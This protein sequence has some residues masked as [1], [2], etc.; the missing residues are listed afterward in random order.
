M[1]KLMTKIVILGALGGC[2]SIDSATLTEG[3]ELVASWSKPEV[4]ACDL[5]LSDQVQSLPSDIALSVQRSN[6]GR[7]DGLNS[8]RPWV[9]R[10]DLQT[11]EFG[12]QLISKQQDGQ[13]MIT[14][15]N[16]HPTK[17]AIL[18]NHTWE[19][20]SHAL[21]EESRGTI[22]MSKAHYRSDVLD[23]E[24]DTNNV[25]NLTNDSPSYYNAGAILFGN[26]ILFTAI[27]EGLGRTW[28]MNLD[29]SHKQPFTLTQGYTY[30]N[31]VSPDG[32]K[33]A[34]HAN[35][36]VFIGDMATKVET[37][38]QTPCNF[39]FG[40]KWSKDSQNI[41]FKCGAT[42]ENP[43]I[44]VADRNGQNVRLL[45]TLG[46]YS[47][48]VPFI[49]GFD[50]HGGGSDRIVW[51]SNGVIHGKKIGSSIEI[52]LSKLDGTQVRLTNT[53]NTHNSYPEVSKDGQW[54]LFHSKVS[55]GPMNL[56][57]INLNT[58]DEIQVTDMDQNCNTRMGF[59]KN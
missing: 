22:I 2:G 1:K 25:T 23:V 51:A 11:K 48:S 57:V 43:D 54:V 29:G 49:D 30:G 31:S 12:S 58:L 52:V 19:D 9:I 20:P 38:V 44:Y 33:Y 26:K 13:V 35:Y 47:S 41:M 27:L 46:G 18:L 34:F 15:N 42:N 7:Y 5:K 32:T 53:T 37:Q 36:K 56:K 24:L 8:H 16:W 28:S 21:L 6:L 17:D 3:H 14:I 59:W 4:E 39:N 50:H 55:Q 45:A 40:P 10:T